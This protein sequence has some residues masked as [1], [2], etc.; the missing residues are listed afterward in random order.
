M[1]NRKCP[2]VSIYISGA[3]C[4]YNMGPIEAYPDCTGC[5]VPTLSAQGTGFHCID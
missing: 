4:I 3:E 5:P 2:E 1:T